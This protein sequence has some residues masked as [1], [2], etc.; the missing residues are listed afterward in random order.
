MTDQTPTPKTQPN[1]PQET[2]AEAKKPYRK[3][4]IIPGSPENPVPRKQT[5][6]HTRY[7]S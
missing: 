7:P 4:T 6:R 3:V 1:N 5:R 2:K